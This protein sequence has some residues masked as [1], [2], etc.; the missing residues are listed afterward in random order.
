M[1]R[2]GCNKRRASSPLVPRPRA[3]RPLAAVLVPVLALVL[4][5]PFRAARCQCGGRA[6]GGPTAGAARGSG[7]RIIGRSVAQVYTALYSFF[8]GLSGGGGTWHAR[9][10]AALQG[11]SGRAD[12]AKA[13]GG[14]DGE[15]GEMV[16]FY[17]I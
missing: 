8:K 13:G 14:G 11:D 4:V 15:M 1:Q 9:A 5:L 10:R 3:P 6:W 17:W 2:S 7:A 12:G 16:F